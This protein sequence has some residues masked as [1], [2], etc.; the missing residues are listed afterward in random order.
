M[1]CRSASAP[2]PAA[3]CFLLSTFPRAAQQRAVSI[4]SGRF[5]LTMTIAIGLKK[6]KSR[7]EGDR[8][9]EPV[10]G[11]PNLPLQRVY[12]ESFYVT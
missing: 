11:N 1:E 9:T 4:G 10:L 2:S 8:F 3:R 7:D 6:K 5:L 12:T